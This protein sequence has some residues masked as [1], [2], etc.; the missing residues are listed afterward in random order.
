[1]TDVVLTVDPDRPANASRFFTAGQHLLHLLDELTDRESN[2][3][4]WQIVDLRIGSAVSTVRSRSPERE[5]AA[6]RL[7]HGLGTI[8]SGRPAPQE[9]TPG[10]TGAAQTLVR[11]LGRS[12]ATV[13]VG[14][15]VVPIDAKLGARL[16][17]IT[18]WVREMPGSLRGMLTGFNV[19]RGNRASLKLE[20]GRVVRCSFPTAETQHMADSLLKF[21]EIEGLVRQDGDGPPYWIGA[22]SVRVIPD[23]PMPWE[24]LIG[25]DTRIT[26]GMPVT[27]YLAVI[28]GEE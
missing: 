24:D 9:W 26:D 12:E 2:L 17:S 1:M 10:A 7:I 5:V 19:T 27:E 18:P 22:E 15:Q 3:D 4:D 23:A 21:V 14:N 8:R 11:D 28:R 6:E 20:S 25:L 13:Q 16:E